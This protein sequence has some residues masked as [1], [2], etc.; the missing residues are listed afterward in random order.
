MVAQRGRHQWQ[1]TY[2]PVAITSEATLRPGGVY[3]VVGDLEQGLGQVWASSLA[4]QYQAKVALISKADTNVDVK[5]QLLEQ[6]A[7][8]VLTLTTEVTQPAQLQDAVTQ[9]VQE[10]GAINGSFLST[11]TTN[12]KSAAPITLLQ[13]EQLQYNHQIKQKVLASL[14]AV[15][16][17]KSDHSPDFCCVQA[18]LSSVIGGVGLAAYAGANH[19][20]DAMVAQQNQ[21]SPFPWFS[22]NWDAWSDGTS[23]GTGWGSTLK[24]FALTSQEVWTATERI[25]TQVPG[26]IVISKGSLSDRIAKWIHPSPRLE[27]EADGKPQ[28]THHRPQISTAY[29][30]PRN[31]VEKTI[32]GI[33]QDLLG[34]EQVGVHDSFFDLGGHSLLAIQVI[35]RLR[36]AFPVEVEMRNLLFEAPT[37]AGIAAVIAEQ[38]PQTE[39][40]DTMAALLAEVQSLSTEEVQAQLAGGEA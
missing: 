8:A 12:E 1:Q 6:G 28:S 21:Q 31:E 29:V 25:L 39:E 33:W 3:V 22:V 23:D 7:A 30:A 5:T 20:L 11:P 35:S 18:S 40:L 4:K 38:L 15:L 26:Q 16:G 17:D 2:Q 27:P 24:D 32:A 9:V 36:E 37:V 10:L 13:P 19:V 34:L 14:V